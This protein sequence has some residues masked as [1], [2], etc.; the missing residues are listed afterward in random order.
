MGPSLCMFNSSCHHSFSQV[1]SST[2]SAI[3]RSIGWV[4][5]RVHL[6]SYKPWNTGCVRIKRSLPRGSTKLS[7]LVDD[8]EDI[9]KQPITT[10]SCRLCQFVPLPPKEMRH[11]HIISNDSYAELYPL[12]RRE[13]RCHTR[14]VNQ[15]QV[16]L[17][18]SSHVTE[19][20][21]VTTWGTVYGRIHM[22]L[23]E[24]GCG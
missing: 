11:K 6:F 3:P 5:R 2:G 18:N 7:F 23:S 19:P 17:A 1:V 8:D 20:R 15:T 13:M 16:K 22:L 24:D 21:F 9:S 4:S 12:E 10:F 14:N